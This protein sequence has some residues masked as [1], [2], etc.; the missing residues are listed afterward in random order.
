MLEDTPLKYDI[1]FR[2]GA[3]LTRTFRI[4]DDLGAFVDM[5]GWLSD[6][7]VRLTNR[8]GVPTA[9]VLQSTSVYDA[10]ERAWTVDFPVVASVPLLPSAGG[11][12]FGVQYVWDWKLTTP[13]GVVYVVLQGVVTVLRRVTP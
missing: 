11:L 2:A 1:T 4:R 5:T 6:A 12:P 8:Y 9:V 7:V 10:I 13:A 3:T